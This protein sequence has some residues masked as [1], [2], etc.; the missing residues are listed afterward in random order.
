MHLSKPII[1]CPPLQV[2]PQQE[3]TRPINLKQLSCRLYP[4]EEQEPRDT[5][6]RGSSLNSNNSSSNNIN[7]EEEERIKVG[8]IQVRELMVQGEDTTS[9]LMEAMEVVTTREV[10][11]V[12][13]DENLARWNK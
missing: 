7:K 13:G 5:S 1:R 9:I 10:K 6:I 12:K 8:N 3:L 2:L 4:E 11:E